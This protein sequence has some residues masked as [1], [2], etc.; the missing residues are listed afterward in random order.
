MIRVAL[1]G[2][3]ARPVRTALTTLAIVIGVAFVCAAYTLT[4][5]MSGAADSL[6]HAAYDGTDA[7]VVTKTAFRGSQTSDVRAQAPTISAAALERVRHADGVALAVGDITDT[8]Q[9][10]GTDGKPVGTGPYF[11]IGFDADDAGRRAADAVPPARGQVGDRS[12]PGR[13][14]PRHRRVAALRRRRHDPR[15]RPRRGRRREGHRHRRLRRRQVAR[16]GE[17]GDLRPRDGP[18]RCSPRTATT[19]SSSARTR[20]ATSGRRSRPPCRARRSAARPTT[21]ASRSTRSSCS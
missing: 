5:T 12:R 21:T 9:V 15:R 11:G 8:A 16:Q 7:V 2:L 20:A 17:R 18:R 4:D 3:A 14:R 1:K 6:T 19:A 13:D 10:I